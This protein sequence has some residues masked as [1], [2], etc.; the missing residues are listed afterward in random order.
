DLVTSIFSL[1]HLTSRDDLIACLRD[2][3]SLIRQCG[4]S[5]WIFDHVRPRRL[6][7]AEEFPG[8]FTPHSSKAFCQDS[9]N[10]LRASWSFEELNESLKSAIAAPFESAKTRI[11]PLYQ[12]HWS[13][14]RPAAVGQNWV[15]TEALTGKARGEAYALHR[16]FAR[17]PC[18]KT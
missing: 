7:T 2:I 18:T 9:T 5:V 11:V 1:H 17:T 16:L 8:I 3:G 10:S 6:R 12:I 4:T 14:K 13:R 15:S